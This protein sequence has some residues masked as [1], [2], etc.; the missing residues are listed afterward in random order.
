MRWCLTLTTTQISPKYHYHINMNW[1]W[2]KSMVR[3]AICDLQLWSQSL[4]LHINLNADFKNDWFLG[5]VSSSEEQLR[6]KY[7]QMFIY[8]LVTLRK[9]RNGTKIDFRITVLRKECRHAFKNNEPKNRKTIRIQDWL[10]HISHLSKAKTSPGFSLAHQC[11]QFIP[12][13]AL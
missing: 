8:L 2:W 3:S 7:F 4:L 11:N 5:L 9:K 10:R 13:A 6:T 12:T 1:I